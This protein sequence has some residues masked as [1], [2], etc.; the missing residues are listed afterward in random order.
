[1]KTVSF[2]LCA[3]FTSMIS[4][5]RAVTLH[6]ENMS[7]RALTI[8]TNGES[9]SHEC[10]NSVAHKSL[11]PTKNTME[12]WSGF[13]I[14]FAEYVKEFSIIT[15]PSHRRRDK[16]SK[17][18]PLELSQ[19]RAFKIVSCFGWVCNVCHNCWHLCRC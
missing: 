6:L 15:L 9:G 2:M 18:T 5:W 7:L 3:W 12:H 16:K 11:K 10:S 4:C 17:I 14:S 13:E 1:M 19:F 8:C